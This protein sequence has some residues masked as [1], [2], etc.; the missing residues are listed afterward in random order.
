MERTCSIC[1]F[2]KPIDEFEKVKGKPHGRGY[3][4]LECTNKRVKKYTANGI[5]KLTLRYGLNEN[6]AR[7][8]REAFPRCPICNRVSGQRRL[9]VDHDHATDA[10]RGVLCS[11]CNRAIGALGDSQDGLQRAIEYLTKVHPV[12]AEINQQVSERKMKKIKNE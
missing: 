3:R 7:R 1:K 6:E 11:R 8:L 10:I 12:V 4:C 2:P 5:Y 9:C